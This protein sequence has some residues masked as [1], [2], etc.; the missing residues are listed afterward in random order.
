M[1]MPSSLA[2]SWHEAVE[3]CYFHSVENPTMIYKMAQ[4]VSPEKDTENTVWD[5]AD[6]LLP[7]QSPE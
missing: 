7:I 3:A 4:F 5:V 2:G 1:E 6:S